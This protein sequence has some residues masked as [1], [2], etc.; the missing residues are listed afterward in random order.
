MWIYEINSGIMWSW[1]ILRKS[2]GSNRGS[3]GSFVVLQSLK[4]VHKESLNDQVGSKV[5]KNVQRE[6]RGI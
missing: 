6:S 4:G 1:R 2:L 5:I 3:K